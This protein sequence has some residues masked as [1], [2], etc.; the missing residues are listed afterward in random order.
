[1]QQLI[2]DLSEFNIGEKIAFDKLEAIQI[3]SNA[4][5]RATG[6]HKA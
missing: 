2:P 5:F 4:Y 6:I 1:M 3:K